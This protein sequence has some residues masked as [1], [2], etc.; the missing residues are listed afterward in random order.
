MSDFATVD[1][2]LEI[3]GRNYTSSE[4]DRI[5]TLLPLV[6][7]ALRYEAEK[8]GKNLDDMITESPPYASVVKLVTID[9]V[10]R[11]MRQSFEGEP[12]AQETQSALGY[13]WQGSYAVSG[14]GIAASIMKNDLKRLGLR[15]QRYGMEG[16]FG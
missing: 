8:V 3:S 13:S 11:A 5:E 6:S 16:M 12:L 1:D 10:I 7:D 4:Q 15:R 14:G 9:V 2:V